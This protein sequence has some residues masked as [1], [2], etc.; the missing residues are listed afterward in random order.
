MQDI[1]RNP[2]TGRTAVVGFCICHTRF[3]PP[4]RTC[5]DQ[6]RCTVGKDEQCRFPFA[7]IDV[8]YIRDLL[9]STLAELP[10]LLVV[11]DTG[12]VI[13]RKTHI[14]SDCRQTALKEIEF[15]FIGLNF[16]NICPDIPHQKRT[17][18][19]DNL[20][21]S[22]KMQFA[23]QPDLRDCQDLFTDRCSSSCLKLAIATADVCT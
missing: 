17:G 5:I 19:T 3:G 10:R 18:F 20:N 8:M 13:P 6:H 2:F 21:K 16:M 22:T 23:R 11:P 7:G 12:K 9:L 15:C 4:G 14:K 1:P